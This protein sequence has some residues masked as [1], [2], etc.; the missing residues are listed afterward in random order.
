MNDEPKRAPSSHIYLLLALV[1]FFVVNPF[2]QGGSVER[3]VFGILFTAVLIFGVFVIIHKPLLSICMIMLIVINLTSYWI[4]SFW[5]LR[6]YGVILERSAAIIFFLVIIF[7]LLHHILSE[8]NIS[9]NTL[10]DAISVYLLVGLSWSFI[11]SLLDATQLNAFEFNDLVSVSQVAK[12]ESFIYYS[13]V[14]LTTLGYGDITP[15]SM[16]AKTFAW[17]EAVV[18]QV[19][20]T[21]L[22]AHFVGLHVA[23]RAQ[24]DRRE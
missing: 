21:V 19:Y 5:D 8:R 11:Y 1:A 6:G 24:N 23:Q 14:T 2:V 4:S 13:F 7:S 16:P 17:L 9:L 12:E 10:Y 22:I 20:V 3:Y 18:G 15:L